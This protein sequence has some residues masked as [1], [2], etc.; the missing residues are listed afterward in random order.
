MCMNPRFSM[1]STLRG[2]RSALAWAAVMAGVAV[3]PG[4]AAAAAY[5]DRPIHYIIPFPPG[6]STDSTGRILADEM[7]KILGQPVVV[8]NRGGA[9]GNIGA[10][11]VAAAAPDGYT[12]LQGTIGTHGINP[13]LY[14]NTGFDA[15]NDFEPI[16]RMTAGTNVL[17][18]NPEVPAK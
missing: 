10:T 12:L 2:M 5:P 17:V 3:A 9:G 6:G 1:R 11:H 4:L 8:E 7:S 18:V 13:T 16:A 14:E 15:R